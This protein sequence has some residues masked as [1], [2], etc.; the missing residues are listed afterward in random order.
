MFREIRLQPHGR[1]SL[2]NTHSI[3][4]TEIGTVIILNLTMRIMEKFTAVKNRSFLNMDS[5]EMVMNSQQENI[6]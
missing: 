6:S 1:I 4:K 3:M 2:T 5:L